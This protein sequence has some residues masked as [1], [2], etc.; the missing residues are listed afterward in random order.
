M[1]TDRTTGSTGA[2]DGGWSDY[3]QNEGASGE[4]FVDAQGRKHPSLA[5]YWARVFDELPGGTRVVDLA[6]GAGSVYAQLPAEHDLELYATDISAEALTLL[7]QKRPEVRTAVCGSDV[8]SYEYRSFALVVSQ[9][10]I[11]YAG[12]DAFREAARLVASP[13]RLVVLCHYEDG[14]ID[15]RNRAELAGAKIAA[16][17]DFIGKALKLTAAAFSGERQALEAAARS[18]IPAER[19]LADAVLE[20]KQGVHAHLYAGFRRLYE[21]RQQYLKSDIVTWLGEMQ[22]ELAKNLHRLE[23]MCGAALS[24]DDVDRIRGMLESA[25]LSGISVEPFT[26]PG[27]D[28][29]IAWELR[30]ARV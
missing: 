18:F 9:F 7:V 10:G 30:A 16:E 2:A 25:G 11:E 15:A 6:A 12:I 4:V 14:Y 3:W 21:N 19:A 23:C 24:R 17:T 26:A 5:A 27:H 20:R 1:A 8:V 13:G 22:G 29:P 28:L